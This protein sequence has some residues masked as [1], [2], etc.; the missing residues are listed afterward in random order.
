ME[1]CKGRVLPATPL[2]LG[3]CFSASAQADSISFFLDQSDTL[4]DGI[5]YLQ[6]TVSDG[7]AGDIDFSVAV[8]SD[9]FDTAGTSNFGMQTFSFNYDASLS[10][11]AANI[12]NV[13]PSS[14]NIVEDKNAGGG[15]GKFE[16][17]LKGNGST[18]TE[19][20]TFSISGVSGDTV[21]DYA[22]GATATSEF[23]AAHVAGFNTTNGVTSAQF[24]GS[25]PAVVPVPAA[26]WLF[27]SGLLALS[28]VA[29]RRRAIVC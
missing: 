20:L 26:V 14:W 9:A 18:R 13:D 6:V 17:Q 29:R 7:A 19:L 2:L 3:L 8:L 27:G 25:T 15:F 21:Y 12:V 4:D 11:S 5:N 22:L 24:A 10:I 16:F 28:G 1:F 23:F